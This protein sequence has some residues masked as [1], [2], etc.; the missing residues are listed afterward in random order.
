MK[1]L[2]RAVVV[3]LRLLRA[4]DLRQMRPVWRDVLRSRRGGFSLF[5]RLRGAKPN[6]GLQRRKL[7]RLWP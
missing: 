1:Q 2:L 7:N 4:G 3:N 5:K 6:V